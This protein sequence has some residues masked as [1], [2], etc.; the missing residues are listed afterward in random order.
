MGIKVIRQF[1]SDGKIKYE[2]L[3]DPE[4]IRGLRCWDESGEPIPEQ[5]IDYSKDDVDEDMPIRLKY[6]CKKMPVPDFSRTQN[7]NSRFVVMGKDGPL[8]G[9]A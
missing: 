8:Y 6:I 7:Q 3:R 4:G 1:Y 2:Y 5:Y 9:H